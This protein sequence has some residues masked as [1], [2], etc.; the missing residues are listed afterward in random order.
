MDSDFDEDIALPKTVDKFE[1]MIHYL[2][3][4]NILHWKEVVRWAEDNA[5]SVDKVK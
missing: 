4:D 2:E 1:V 5:Y 3:N